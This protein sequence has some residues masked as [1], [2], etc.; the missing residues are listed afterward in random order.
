MSEWLAD[1]LS[2]RPGDFLMFAPRTYWR[3]FELHNEAWWPLHVP[4]VLCAAAGVFAVLQARGSPSVWEKRLGLAALA[5]AS[6]LV[7]WSF[8]WQRYAPINWAAEGLAWALA[9][10]ALMLAALAATGPAPMAA[11]VPSQPVRRGAA[12][13]M[14]AAVAAW[15][16]AGLAGH[17]WRAAEV[18]G[19]APDP[20]LA[21]TLA[22]LLVVRPAAAARFVQ[23]ATWL[24]AWWLALACTAFSAATLATMGSPQAL[25]PA[26]AAVGAV[27]LLRQ[28]R[29][30]GPLRHIP[31]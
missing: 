27:A 20:T 12:V 22:W 9:W 1:W 7:A 26:A 21:A 24:A 11:G 15:P 3:L 18:V 29:R 25:L 6:L 31:E 13:L 4:A 16:A 14:L 2:H 5:G 23:R 28:A 10:L 8:A 17:S 19:L 30:T